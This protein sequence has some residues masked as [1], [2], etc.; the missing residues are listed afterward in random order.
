MHSEIYIFLMFQD[1]LIFPEIDDN[2]E[3]AELENMVQPIEKYFTEECKG[4]INFNKNR[5]P[6]NNQL[7]YF[8]LIGF[9]PIC[10]TSKCTWLG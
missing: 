9:D 7:L 4:L 3:L 10:V 2:D 8:Q 1:V 6:K 5:W